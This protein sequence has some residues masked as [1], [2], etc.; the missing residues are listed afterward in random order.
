MKYVHLDIDNA[1]AL[2]LW[3]ELWAWARRAKLLRRLDR[4]AEAEAH[5]QVILYVVVILHVY[6][7]FTHLSPEY[8]SSSISP[9]FRLFNHTGP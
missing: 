5:K 2:G 1:P 8:G 7:R 6:A 4:V 9:Y 3:S